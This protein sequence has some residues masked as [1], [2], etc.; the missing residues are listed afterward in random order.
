MDEFLLADNFFK[1]MFFKNDTLIKN[2]NPEQFPQQ[3]LFLPE[4]KVL[5]TCENELESALPGGAPAFPTGVLYVFFWG[6][7]LNGTF[8]FG[9]LKRKR[10]QKT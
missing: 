3:K 8:P 4:M 10:E 5:I 6:Y 2:W 9:F 7:G 1:R